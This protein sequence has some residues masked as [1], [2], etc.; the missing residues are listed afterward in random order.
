[1]PAMASVSVF[2]FSLLRRR[3]RPRNNNRKGN[4]SSS[5]V[6]L[7]TWLVPFSSVFFFL[8]ELNALAYVTS[9]MLCKKCE[10]RYAYA[11]VYA[12]AYVAV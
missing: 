4:I 6:T 10:L 12:H 11:Y 9:L 7:E 3:F 5:S 8:L 2:S 1:M